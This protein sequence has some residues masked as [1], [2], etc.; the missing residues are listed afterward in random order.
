MMKNNRARKSSSTNYAIF[1]DLHGLAW[2][3]FGCFTLLALFSY[4][5][6]DSS[7]FTAA[8]RPTKNLAGVVG[9]YWS[10]FLYQFFGFSAFLV[11]AMCFFTSIA[12]FR[13]AGR[14]EWILAFASNTLLL[15]MCAATLALIGADNNFRGSWIRGGGLIGR[16][17]ASFLRFYLN[18]AG[19]LLTTFF[20]F[21]IAFSLSTRIS[22]KKIVLGLAALLAAS[23]LSTLALLRKF[24]T[25][26]FALARS[27]KFSPASEP[28][29]TP[30]MPAK[31]RLLER[32]LLCLHNIGQSQAARLEETLF[33][34]RP[35]SPDALEK[36]AIPPPLDANP[37]ANQSSSGPEIITLAAKPLEAELSAPEAAKKNS[38]LGYVARAAKANE[39]ILRRVAGK[40]DFTLPA[41]NL[42]RTPVRTG[43][44]YNRNE[45]IANSQVLEEKI[46]D[47]KIQG[48]I[49]SVKPGPVITMYEFKPGTGVKVNSIAAL[50]DDLALALSAQSVRIEAPIPGRDVVG[51]E[52]PNVVREEVFLKEIIDTKLFRDKKF[53][54]PI[55]IGKDTM[56]EPVVHDLRRMPHMLVA[57]ATG[58]GKSVF[59][60]SL[61]CSL[62]FRFN[63]NDLKL[64][65]VDPKQLELA[66]YE[67]I[68]HLLLP[69][70]TEAKKASLALRWAVGE[71]E[72]RY[73]MIARSGMR[74][75]DGFNQKLSELGEAA[76]AERLGLKEEERAEAMPKI[77]IVIDELADLM[78]TARSD[79]ENNICR[80]AQ[81][82]RAAGIHLVLATQRPSVDVITGLIKANLPARLSFRLSSKNDSRTI[83]DCMGAERLV[84]NGDM[85]FMP[86]GESRLVRM[87]GAYISEAEIESVVA[88]WRAQ[89]E[90]EYREEILEDHDDED[91]G[92]AGFEEEDDSLFGEAVDVAIASGIVSASMLQRRFRIGYNRAARMVE[93][94]EARGI[95]GPAEGAKPRPVLIQK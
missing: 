2:I 38:L 34:E 70:V 25:Q 53:S 42:L 85:L 23:A 26:T 82:A 43:N 5:Q 84:G 93:L 75:V 44:S 87:H 21:V 83:F 18:E 28:A 17:L 35:R 22:V 51:I 45:L 10:A 65:L 3:F 81:K 27:K 94:M 59:I 4:S 19:A 89:A 9:S 33:S 68:P 30:L 63:P 66:F 13:R 74:D 14:S 24:A 40:V 92:G 62:L 32:M 54:I 79:V 57:G 15:L 86:P 20:L 56:G 8:D 29:T 55:A 49:S 11:G 73:Q 91:Q 58:S 60:N 31:K 95:V 16:E 72:R 64:I 78:M 37:P 71:M 90:P 67:S 46:R 77:V 36:I 50:A 1:Q 52:V 6:N 47:F 7:W 76:M 12:I 39:K 88:H 48:S 41:P 69:V 61:I 80:L